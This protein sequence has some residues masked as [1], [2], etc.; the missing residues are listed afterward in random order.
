LRPSFRELTPRANWFGPIKAR[1]D[2]PTAPEI[3]AS[4][5]GPLDTTIDHG[6]QA[7]ERAVKGFL[8]FHDHLM[9][10]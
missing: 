2:L 10:E 1:N 7:A 8:A 5:V 9:A 4:P 3:G 6:Q